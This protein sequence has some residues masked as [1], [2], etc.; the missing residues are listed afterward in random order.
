MEKIINTKNGVLAA[1]AA[2]GG[3]ISHALG[4]WDA[5]LQ[6]LIGFMAAD[7]ITGLMVAAVWQR[8]NK[9]ASGA[10]D[11]KASFKGLCKKV[12]VLAFVWL[13]EMLDRMTGFDYVRTAIILFF[14]GNEGLSFL[15]NV[16]L[17]GEDSPKFLRKILEVMRDNGDSGKTG[18]K[19][20][21]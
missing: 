10:L 15:E 17:M 3:F 21:P 2:I 16:A 8:S 4:G 9:S 11:S 6:V 14:I 12:T 7:Y 18:G 13:G 19:D 1:L 20:E 5:A